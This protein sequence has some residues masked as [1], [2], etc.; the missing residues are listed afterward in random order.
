MTIFDTD[1]I[2]FL[3]DPHL[4]S[5][6]PVSRID[7]FCAATL[8]KLR[9]VRD[10]MVNRGRKHLIILGDVFHKRG[11]SLSYLYQVMQVLQEFRAAGIWVGAIVGNH[12]LAYEDMGTL[13]GSPLGLFFQSGLIEH[14]T[15]A[16]VNAG[17]YSVCLKGFDYPE[18]LTPA[19]NQDWARVSV[20]V[21]HRFYES[22]LDVGSI[23]QEDLVN[24]GY[25]A[26]VLGHDHVSYDPLAIGGRL[27]LRPGGMMRGTSHGYN[28]S[29]DVVVQTVVFKGTKQSPSMGIETDKLS[30]RPAGEVFSHEAVSKEDT[31]ENLSADITE[32]VEGLLAK[33][34]ETSADTSVYDYL[35]QIE[36]LPAVKQTVEHYLKE[37]GIFRREVPMTQG[38]V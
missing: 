33:M 30:I 2:T 14:F 22:P 10:L 35:D 3:G 38:A 17:E 28:L 32:R 5:S 36:A 6:C 11:Q 27:L 9:Q 25:Q 12:D 29:R 15:E 26:Y 21:A 8:D 24:L 20:C 16:Q 1:R 23:K 13:E 7:D 34:D 4:N 31:L 18:T 19:Q 37:K